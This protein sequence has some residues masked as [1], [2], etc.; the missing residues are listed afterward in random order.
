MVSPEPTISA[1]RFAK[2]KCLHEP[3]DSELK[4]TSSKYLSSLKKTQGAQGN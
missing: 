3:Q 4:R 1:E 2:E